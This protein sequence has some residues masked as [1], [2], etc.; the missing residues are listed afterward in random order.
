MSNLEIESDECGEY[1]VE[2]ITITVCRPGRRVHRVSKQFLEEW[3]NV[4]MYKNKYTRV[5]GI[6]WVYILMVYAFLAGGLGAYIVLN[7]T[8]SLLLEYW[9]G[10]AIGMCI[11]C[12]MWR[13]QERKAQH[14]EHTHRTRM[15]QALGIESYRRHE[16]NVNV[17]PPNDH[18]TNHVLLTQ[19]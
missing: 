15:T 11:L 6:H 19:E 3:E 9:A 7:I 17:G 8:P 5:C 1:L 14:Y 16:V 2:P 12:Y 18:P 4:S 13:R 10:A